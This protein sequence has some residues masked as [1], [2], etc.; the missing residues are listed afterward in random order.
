MKLRK[1]YIFYAYTPLILSLLLSFY[2]FVQTFSS[3]QD[4]TGIEKATML[5][6]T[7]ADSLW[8]I[9]YG[10]V[11]SVIIVVILIVLSSKDNNED[12]LQ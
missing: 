10:S 5:A 2:F 1:K 9:L 7:I 6:K 11:L 8:L 3:A 12:N 4:K